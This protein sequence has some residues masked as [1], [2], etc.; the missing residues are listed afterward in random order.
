[1]TE[2][3]LTNKKHG[4]PMLLLLVALYALAVFGIINSTTSGNLTLTGIC[5]AYLVLGWI[6]FAGLKTLK[7]SGGISTHAFRKVLRNSKR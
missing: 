6:P 3:L 7:P 2:K 1:M 5:G 4:I